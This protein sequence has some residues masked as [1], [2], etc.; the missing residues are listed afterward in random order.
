MGL[1]LLWPHLTNAH[2]EYISTGLI[3]TPKHHGHIR[4][5]LH[6]HVLL[7][8]PCCAGQDLAQLSQAC[9]HIYLLIAYMVSM[10]RFGIVL[11]F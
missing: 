10:R 5:N 7:G 1:V 2:K 4:N 8:L 11:T 3:R 6:H 9:F